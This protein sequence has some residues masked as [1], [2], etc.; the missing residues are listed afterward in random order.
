M[1]KKFYTK[2]FFHICQPKL[3]Q[4]I[5]ILRFKSIEIVEVFVT[6]NYVNI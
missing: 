4:N 3:L 5:V 6:I 1:E 2:G